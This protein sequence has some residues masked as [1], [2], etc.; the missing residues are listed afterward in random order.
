MKEGGEVVQE[1]YDDTKNESQ[2]I[3]AA[4]IKKEEQ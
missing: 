3:F 4:Y 2:K 1:V